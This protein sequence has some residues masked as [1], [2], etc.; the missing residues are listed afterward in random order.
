ML[1]LKL[2]LA[3][4][5]TTFYIGSALGQA[6][7][8]DLPF[9][10]NDLG[11]K[12]TSEIN[13]K[14]QLALPLHN[15]KF[16]VAGNFTDLGKEGNDHLA[17]FNADG[18]TD[19]TFSCPS[20]LNVSFLEF[21]DAIELED[22]AVVLVGTFNRYNGDTVRNIIKVNH[23]GSLDKRFC[24][25]ANP[26]GTIRTISLQKDGKF[27]V[28][29]DFS[30]IY[31]QPRQK[32]ARLNQDGSLD[33]VFV[34]GTP[35][36]SFGP[37]YIYDSKILEDGT[38]LIGGSFNKYN[39]SSHLS[40]LVPLDSIG[41]VD[42]S[43]I[44]FGTAVPHTVYS[45]KT[46]A[47][48]KIV[49]GGAGS[50][51]K[52][53]LPS[54]APDHS[55]T[56]PSFSGSVNDLSL[57]SDESIIIV[58]NLLNIND[59]SQTG[60][61]KIGTDGILDSTFK[62]PQKLNGNGLTG[63]V[64]DKNQILF[65]GLFNQYEG[66]DLKYLTLINSDGSIDKSSKINTGKLPTGFNKVVNK[67]LIQPDQKIIVGGDFN[68][69]FE[70]SVGKIARLH[71]DGTLDPSFT[72]GKGFSGGMVKA[73]AFQ[74]NQIIVGGTFNA[75]NGINAF[76]IAR[77]NANGTLDTTFKT[78]TGVGYG[79]S[80][81]GY[82]HVAVNCIEV[83][84]SG[85]IYLAGRITEYD[86]D[87]TT[88]I[89]RLNSDGTIDPTFK[90]QYD[91]TI[92]QAN[93]GVKSIAVQADGKVI[94]VG[95]IHTNTANGRKDYIF[96]LNEDGTI[97]DTFTNSDGSVSTWARTC[98]TQPDGKIIVGGLFA[99]MG[100]SWGKGGI[101]RLLPDG[102]FD[103]TFKTGTGAN[104]NNVSK[105]I[106]QKDGKIIVGGEF[107]S[108]NGHA[109][110]RL[111]RLEADGT[112][113][114]TFS[115]GSGIPQTIFGTSSVTTA[116]VMDIAVQADGNILI[117]GELFAY[118]GVGRNHLVRIFGNSNVTSYEPDQKNETTELFAFP[119]P[120]A[121]IFYLNQKITFAQ[122]YNVQG[123]LIQSYQDTQVIN[124]QGLTS[125]TYFLLT[126]IESIKLIIE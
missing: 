107:E 4:I 63:L 117:A 48:G 123:E 124:V 91:I 23:D 17:R 67:I 38:L 15:G 24:K 73:I 62:G 99:G 32:L 46:Q 14:V 43:K 49:V 6:G 86:G 125:G 27:I 54:G 19:S 83:L 25:N 96:R 66:G 22:S 109:M 102:K 122:L 59:S 87:T 88:H 26:Y 5:V 103:S 78:G 50:M 58:G 57:L 76:G 116:S 3:L 95:N 71:D 36:E 31:G 20:G 2:V 82:H 1:K 72:I 11:Y 47:D 121:G 16:L 98:A 65:G 118:N 80:T 77:L 52:R 10:S 37:A 105:I 112:I 119:N 89:L 69:F 106:V 42:T 7:A 100:N 97:D 41:N 45:I 60:I 30:Q 44:H 34:P 113:D 13:S 68:T 101:I 18:T 40:H 85:K 115:V 56:Q 126:E 55:F 64:N 81:R 75:F 74:G 92:G 93:Y 108:F 9:L 94:L 61:L 90:P 35:S 39:G 120:S 104:G 79:Y 53:F 21:Y 8:I 12:L 114:S 84:A 70:D 51:L 33:T 110:Q 111:I 28:G 29:G